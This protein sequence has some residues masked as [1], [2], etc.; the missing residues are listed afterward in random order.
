MAIR[1]SFRAGRIPRPVCLSTGLV[2]LFC[3]A[4]SSYAQISFTSAIG[5]ALQ[6]SLRVRMAQ[7][8]VNKAVATLTETK[9]AFIPSISVSSGLGASSGITLNVPTIFTINAQSLVFNYSQHDYIRAARL[10][11]QASN[12]ALTDV[13]Q[14][15]EEDAA[16]TYLSLDLA[17]QRRAAMADQ[18]R[19]AL[20]LVS[21]I[22]DRLAAGMESDLELKKSRRTAVQIRLQQLQLDD[23]IASLSDHL[24]RLIGLPGNQLATVPESIPPGPVFPSLAAAPSSYPDT[25]SILSAEANA[26]AKL[27]QAFGDSRYTWRPQVA[28]QAQYGRISPFNGVST[29]YN[30]NGD[31]NTLELGVQIQIPFLDR[32]R[33]AKASESMTDALHAEHQAAY[34]RDQ[35]SENRLKLQHSIAELT[36]KAE[37]AELDQGIAQDQLDAMLLQLKEGNGNSAAPQMTPKDEQNTRIQE[38]QKY[39]DVLDAKLQLRETEIYLL[40]QTDELEAWVQSSSHA[41]VLI[42]PTQ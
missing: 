32:S 1:K 33:K 36:T 42:P 26:R 11:V 34:L 28:F 8:D 15:V 2:L 27:Q 7:D 30:L 13:R 20:K 35:L 21:I 41:P 25:P 19:Y 37:L 3:M 22:Q 31:Y 38:R 14:Q 10:G 18:Y 24:A 23:Q 5:L 40:R 9:D 17:G 16:I 12:M 6:N 39:L 29:Y 4:T